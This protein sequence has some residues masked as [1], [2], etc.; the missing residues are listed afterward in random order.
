MARYG[1]AFKDRAVA[2]LLPPESAALE[3]VAREMG[4]GAGTLQRWREEAQSPRVT[5]L[6]ASIEPRTL[7]AAKKDSSGTIRTSIQG[8]SGSALVAA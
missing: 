8:P 4:V 7:G 1:Q 2:R 3:L 6:V 5:I